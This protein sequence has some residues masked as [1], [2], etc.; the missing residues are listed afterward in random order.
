MF[1]S[2]DTKTEL[3]KMRARLLVNKK[4]KCHKFCVNYTKHYCYFE[5]ND[6]KKSR[7]NVNKVQ[8]RNILNQISYDKWQCCTE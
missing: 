7:K 1:L 8:K 2:S 3:R 4:L 6:Q 5:Y